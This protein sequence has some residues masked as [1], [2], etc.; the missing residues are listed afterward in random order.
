MDTIP[1]FLQLIQ[2][3]TL[4]FSAIM[5]GDIHSLKDNYDGNA[6]Y[7]SE[8]GVR[9]SNFRLTENDVFNVVYITLT[10]ECTVDVS[11][12]T[13]DSKYYDKPEIYFGK[14]TIYSEVEDL[15]IERGL[16]LPHPFQYIFR[17]FVP[18]AYISSDFAATS[19]YVHLSFGEAVLQKRVLKRP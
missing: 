4:L 2:A 15:F 10:P 7:L 6:C 9:L 8:M 19:Y 5:T 13:D 12:F 18:P 3:N 16:R 1:F 11:M 14:K 17:D